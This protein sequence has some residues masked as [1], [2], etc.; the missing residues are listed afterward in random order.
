MIYDE[1]TSYAYEYFIV[2]PESWIF[3]LSSSARVAGD[4]LDEMIE[5][6]SWSG[7]QAFR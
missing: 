6:P 4:W 2:N 7:V 5:A 3:I 1:V